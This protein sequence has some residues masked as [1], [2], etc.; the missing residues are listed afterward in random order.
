MSSERTSEQNSRV[1]ST[2][3]DQLRENSSMRVDVFGAV[4]VG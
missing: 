1:C 3:R 4:K 2:I